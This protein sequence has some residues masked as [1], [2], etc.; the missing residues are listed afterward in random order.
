MA[1]EERALALASGFLPVDFNLSV[2]LSTSVMSA[3]GGT[4]APAADDFFALESAVVRLVLN[5]SDLGD[6]GGT[7]AETGTETDP[8]VL[9]TPAEGLLNASSLNASSLNGS[10]FDGSSFDGSSFDGSSFDGSSVNVSS[11]DGLADGVNASAAN[12][13]SSDLNNANDLDPDL[14]PSIDL[15]ITTP[16]LPP[17]PMLNTSERN[18]TAEVGVGFVCCGAI[19]YHLIRNIPGRMSLR[20]SINVT[21]GTARALWLK[22]ASCPTYPDDVD[23][24]GCAGRCV[25]S[26]LTTYDPYDGAALSH[27]S[28]VA[29]VPNGLGLDDDRRGY[30]DWLVGVQALDGDEA[31]YLLE[32]TLVEPPRE[33]DTFVCD[34]WQWTCPRPVESSLPSQQSEYDGRYPSIALF[35]LASTWCF[36]RRVFHPRIFGNKGSTERAMRREMRRQALYDYRG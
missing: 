10:S 13:S 32:S 9:A 20:V 34:R 28:D 14:D 31:E 12:A 5:A 26:W 15:I 17:L 24:L 11:A 36:F 29:L 2:R 16:P 18:R 23:G 30:G 6:G 3:E 33:D 35:A 27:H 22:H 1:F 19:K 7:G 8:D 25:V 4:V 21:K